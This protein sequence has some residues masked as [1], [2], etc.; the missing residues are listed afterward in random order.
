[1]NSIYAAIDIGS[2]TLKLKIV[3]YVNQNIYVLDDISTTVRIGEDIF[4][5]GNIERDT[6]KEIIRIMESFRNVMDSYH[7]ERYRAVATGAMRSAENNLNVIEMVLMRTGIRIEIIEDTIEKFLTYKSM[8]DNLANYKKIRKSSILVE[9]NTGSCDISV[10]NQNK[11]IFNEEFTMGTLVLKHI[12]RDIESRSINYPEIMSE[13]IESR[14][15]HMWRIIQ[16]RKIEYFLAIG[17]EIKVMKKKL[18]GDKDFIDRNDFE[19]IYQRVMS[20]HLKFRKEIERSGMDWYE[21]VASVLV[22]HTFLR[23]VDTDRLLFPVINIRDGMISELIEEDYNLTKYHVFNNDIL[24]LARNTSIR[25]KSSAK[26]CRMVE[27]NGLEIMRTL[28]GAFPFDER[29]ELLLRLAAILHEIGKFTRTKDYLSTS[30]YKIR[31]LSIMGMNQDEMTLIAYICKFMTD[32]R[33]SRTDMMRVNL[34]NQNLIL[35]LSS[36]LS[37]A[38]SMD[39]SKKQ[40]IQMVGIEITR[41]EFRILISKSGD[42]TLEEWNFDNRK[43]DFINTFGLIP[44]LI[45]V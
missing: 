25:Y 9:L 4:D 16:N 14:T 45:E 24:S 31:N 17:G 10:Y 37:L 42:I 20:D 6:V 41:D 35:K 26:H 22:Y 29:D 39:K 13:F 43:K 34:D 1:M 18:L 30:F 15:S 21:L 8:R 11:L 27:K 44:K 7:V 36:I 5:K 12:M 33:S 19:E 3:Q 28:K 32:S 40:K 2:N 38:D 23:L